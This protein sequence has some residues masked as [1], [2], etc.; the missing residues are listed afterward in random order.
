MIDRMKNLILD[1]RIFYRL[2]FVYAMVVFLS[3][4]GANAVLDV[5]L[6]LFAGRIA[7]MRNYG[8]LNQGV[9]FAWF[10][11]VGVMLLS[12]IVAENIQHSLKAIWFFVYNSAPLFIGCALFR[13]REYLIEIS[14]VMAG[15]LLALS[16]WVIWQGIN[17]VARPSDFLGVFVPLGAQYSQIIPFLA[18]LVLFYRPMDL[19]WRLGLGSITGLALLA[20]VLNATRGAWVAVAVTF[21]VL[22]L[23]SF[24]KHPRLTGIVSLFLMIMMVATWLL[25]PAKMP[26]EQLAPI[27]RDAASVY[28]RL[29][30]WR[31]AANMF[32]DH[33]VMGVG[34]GNFH[35]QFGKKYVLE[36]APEK[37][38][39]HAH[40]TPLNLLAEMGV[41][42]LFA[43]CSLFFMI[44][45]HYGGVYRSSGDVWALAMLFTSVG[46]L[47]QSQSDYN[48]DNFPI[49]MQSY[50]FLAGITWNGAGINS[51]LEAADV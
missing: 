15:S 8:W 47:V 26:S 2:I 41:I 44:F 30:L 33:P 10:A 5:T 40:N 46:L 49:V 27:V 31:S 3:V 38:A 32:S 20:L 24:R 23:F 21:L 25:L 28:T 16:L 4:P 19:K 14:K 51:S 13:Q 17:G 45:R 7:L 22:I 48:L 36:G 42:G 11:L 34:I 50:W 37:S 35:E 29:Y 43:Y 1:D 9:F 39:G 12:V 18:V 6:A